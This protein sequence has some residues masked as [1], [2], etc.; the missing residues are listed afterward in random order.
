MQIDFDFT[1]PDFEEYPPDDF[2]ISFCRDDGYQVSNLEFNGDGMGLSGNLLNSIDFLLR[3]TVEE[4]VGIAAC[5]TIEE[6]LEFLKSDVIDYFYNSINGYLVQSQHGNTSDPLEMEETILLSSSESNGS[7]TSYYNFQTDIPLSIQ[8]VLGQVDESPLNRLMRRFVLDE[9]GHLSLNATTFMDS[10][11]VYEINSEATDAKL[12]L[13]SVTFGGLDTFK[14]FRFIDP[15]GKYTLQNGFNLEE[16]YVTLDLDALFRPQSSD[17]DPTVLENFTFSLQFEDINVESAIF[18]A[19]STEEFENISFGSLLWIDNILPCILATVENA[20]F[21][22]L[23][24]SV[25]NIMPPEYSG[26]DD[27]AAERI[28]SDASSAFVSMYKKSVINALPGFAQNDVLTRLNSL[29]KP[30]KQCF[31]PT[32]SGLVDFHELLIS[33]DDHSIGRYGDVVPTIYGMFQESISETKSDGTPAFN[34]LL[35]KV[36][37]LQSNENGTL[38]FP[39]DIFRTNSTLELDNIILELGVALSDLRVS[40]LNTFGS[41]LKVFQPVDGAT[42]ALNN[43]VTFGVG[44]DPFEITAT[45]LIEANGDGLLDIYNEVTLDLRIRD[46]NLA[47]DVLADIKEHALFNLPLK[48]FLDIQCLLSSL[49]S[50]ILDTFGVRIGNDDRGGVLLRKVE[51]SLSELDVDFQCISCTSQFLQE[52]SLHLMTEEGKQNTSSL[53]ERMFNSI[54]SILASSFVQ[55]ELDKLVYEAQ[56]KCPVS[57]KYNATFTSPNYSVF[58]TSD[59]SDMTSLVVGVLSS[60]AVLAVLSLAVWSIAKIL[61]KRRHIKWLDTLD[62]HQKLILTVRQNAEECRMARLNERMKSLAFS[63][64]IIPL[65]HRVFIPVSLLGNIAL[66]L[67]GHLSPVASVRIIGSILGSDLHI[68]GFFMFSMVDS[69]EEIWEVGA[70]A[71]A[72]MVSIVSIC[73]PYMKQ[74]MLIILWF[75]P[76]KYVSVSRRGTILHWLDLL[77]K[78]SMADIFVILMSLVSF[79]IYIRSPNTFLFLENDLYSINI[80]VVAM[81]GLYANL[82][83]QILSQ[84]LSHFILHYHR[85][86]ID[87][88]LCIPSNDNFHK[89]ILRKHTFLL[90]YEASHLHAVT[91]K[92]VDGVVIFLSFLIIIGVICGCTF[93]SFSTEVFGLVGLAIESGGDGE[94]IESYYSV[95]SMTA[96]IMKTGQSGSTS[97]RIG[98]GFL[99]FVFVATIF[100][101]PIA[102]VASILYHWFASINPLNREKRLFFTESVE[103]WQYMQV[104]VLSIILAALQLGGVSEAMV[105]AVCGPFEHLFSSLSYFGI[106]E[107]RYAKCF[108]IEAYVELGSWL[109]VTSSLLLMLQFHFVSSAAK[110]LIDDEKSNSES[111]K[112]D[113]EEVPSAAEGQ[114]AVTSINPRFTDYYSFA[115]VK[116]QKRLSQDEV[117]L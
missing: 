30:D 11:V 34:D 60:L 105:E 109:L 32:Y 29:F 62:E 77:G 21:T 75:A 65:F 52:M 12:S 96:A 73:W 69:I 98:L 106:L 28:I 57:E 39:G 40:N 108:R 85:K 116:V 44:P 117:E 90:E 86:V 1:S 72:V 43:T 31:T 59:R 51:A 9:D 93:P 83:A 35:S 74:L 41:T 6:K 5:D 45:I 61:T 27:Q 24:A 50:P 58:E 37:E 22:Q 76:T 20:K 71:L 79:S 100:V 102:L 48:H 66:F 103:S 13:S 104:Y 53:S 4:E 89:G 97:D 23:V 42:N 25:G 10:N 64:D 88:P 15:I 80:N 67:S 46:L 16:L 56:Y 36:A 114:K 78:W 2:T 84:I 92:W 81:W 33:R 87:D 26:F 49:D 14:S 47:L 107:E 94:G 3:S 68:D 99:V 111:S 115:V 82:L 38:I 91:R 70:K 19:I 17:S 95:F 101:V 113:I 55:H 112:L 8:S 18:M 54:A 110:Q 63:K 7:S